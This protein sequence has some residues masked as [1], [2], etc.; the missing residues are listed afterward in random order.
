MSH[1]AYSTLSHEIFSWFRFFSVVLLFL[2]FSGFSG[3]CGSRGSLVLVVLWC[4]WLSSSSDSCGSRSSLVLVSLVLV[5]LMV[6]GSCGWLP[7]CTSCQISSDWHGMRPF[8]LNFKMAG[9]EE[10]RSV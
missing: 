8:P 4:L 3:S 9:E 2:W 1:F 10:I 5:V 7:C 6:S